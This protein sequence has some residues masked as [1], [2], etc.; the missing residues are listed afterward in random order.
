M[1]EFQRLDAT[2]TVTMDAVKGTNTNADLGALFQQVLVPL[3]VG[4]VLPITL[5]AILSQ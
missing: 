3:M 5:V 1:L 2:G 4:L